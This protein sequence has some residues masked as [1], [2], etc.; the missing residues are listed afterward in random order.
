[1]AAH[2]RTRP[3]KVNLAQKFGL[4][5]EL[6]SP[7]IVG[8]VNGFHVKIVKVKGE[9]IW[10]RH[11]KEDELFLVTKGRLTIR[12]RGREIPLSAGEFFVVPRGVTHKPV[13]GRE[14]RVVLIEPK[15]V[16]NTG[17]AGGGRTSEAE[18]L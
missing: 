16:V 8:E 1:M 13:A 10:H 5:K 7:K 3:Q 11:P 18:W 14:A 9:F 4:F 2:G 15:S 17:E 6:W 12:L